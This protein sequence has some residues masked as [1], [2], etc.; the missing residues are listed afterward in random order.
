MI[1]YKR[2]NKSDLPNCGTI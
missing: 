1:N 2:N